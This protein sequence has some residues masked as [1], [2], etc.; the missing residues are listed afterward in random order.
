MIIYETAGRFINAIF[1]AGVLVWSPLS[2]A[3]M[4]VPSL[5]EHVIDQTGS[6][7]SEQKST[8]EQSLTE[9]EVRRNSQITVLIVASTA[10]EG[11]EQFSSRAAEQ[12]KLGRKKVDDGAILV[13]AKDDRAVRIEVVYDREGA[14]NDFTTRRIITEIIL[15]RFRQHDFYGG[16]A[17]GAGQMIRVIDGEALPEPK[18]SGSGP[19]DD[20]QRY[21]PVLFIVALFL[22][23]VLRSTIGKVPSAIVTGSVV[24]VVAWFMVGALS[25]AL[26]SAIAAVLFTLTRPV[27]ALNGP[28]GLRSGGRSHLVTVLAL[29]AVAAALVAVV[30][31]AGGW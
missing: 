15:P 28:A 5:T 31:R 2:M 30:Y 20:I 8:L 27:R 24:G 4:P 22:G 1:V 18:R 10:P 3:Q 14:L 6:L 17:A 13:V 19:Q 23:G 29:A 12:W 25:I 11:I 16:I 26:I 21:G 9:F 7:G